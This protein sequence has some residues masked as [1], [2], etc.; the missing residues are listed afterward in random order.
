MSELRQSPRVSCE[1]MLNKSKNG[2]THVCLASNISLGGMRIKRLLDPMTE[3]QDF[4]R[5]QFLVP[6]TNAP[7]WVGAKKVYEQEDYIGLSF[8][9]FKQD[10]FAKLRSWI[11]NA[12]NEENP[13]VEMRVA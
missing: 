2:H 11:L 13:I 3:F 10:S 4:V 9:Y 8:V 12:Q 7:I 5:L 6:G 1:I